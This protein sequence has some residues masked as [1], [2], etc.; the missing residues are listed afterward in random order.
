[1]GRS[2]G[3]REAA[4]F[5]DRRATT[6]KAPGGS[7]LALYERDAARREHRPGRIGVVD[8]RFEGRG[9]EQTDGETDGDDFCRRI[10]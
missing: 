4:S 2:V 6:S 1:M 10:R 8:A 7:D 5:R 9:P 3:D